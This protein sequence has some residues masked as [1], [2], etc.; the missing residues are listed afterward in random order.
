M[1]HIGA[2]LSSSFTSP[3]P[4][5]S[6]LPSAVPAAIRLVI[7]GNNRLIGE[8]I[9]DYCKNRWN[10]QVAR[11]E[12]T[13]R[14]GVM[15]VAGTQPEFAIISLPVDDM[16]AH[17]LVSALH[18]MAPRTR[19]ILHVSRCHEYLIHSLGTTEWDGLLSELDEGLDTFG[20]AIDQV[21]QGLRFVS[22]R[23]QQ[24]Q[25]ALRTTPDAFPKLLSKRLLDVLVCVTHSMSNE[26][27]GARLGISTS[28]ALSHR[29]KIMN[30]LNIHSTPQLIRYCI[31]KGFHADPPPALSQMGPGL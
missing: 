31:E 20:K 15:A 19:I 9:G 26:E 8:L 11:I 13:G 30:K 6:P 7:V 24:C 21:R 16:G 1:A 12:L 22:P 14:A 10:V 25:L 18:E 17:T 4:D 23:I 29:K 27:I 3:I 5:V 28:T 2:A